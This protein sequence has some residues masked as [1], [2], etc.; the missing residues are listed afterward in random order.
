MTR[1]I[2]YCRVST[3]SQAE[4]GVSLATQEAKARAYAELYDLDVVAVI[5][6]EGESAKNLARPG[7]QRALAALKTGEADGLIV[8]KLDRLTRSVMD[9]GALLTDYFQDQAL[10]SVQEQLDA[11]TATGRM[12]LNILMSVAQWQREDIAERTGAALAHKKA[13][14]ERVGQIPYGSR[15]GVD[16]THLEPDPQEQGVIQLMRQWK[17]EGTSY[18]QIVERLNARSIPARPKAQKGVPAGEGPPGRWHLPL[19]HRLVKESA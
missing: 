11:R 17:V 9:L 12:I 5:R 19:V 4:E 10:F 8:L 1:V 7:I 16:G 14:G 15:L 6:D 3:K 18:R 2:I 13:L